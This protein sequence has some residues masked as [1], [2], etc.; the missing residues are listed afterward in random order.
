MT[1]NQKQKH[2]KQFILET[3]AFYFMLLILLLISSCG[4]ARPQRIFDDGG[5]PTSSSKLSAERLNEIRTA[6]TGKAF[7]L[8]ENWY[9]Y[10]YID[11]DPVGGFGE[12]PPKTDIPA[13]IKERSLKLIAPAGTVAEITGMNATRAGYLIFIAQSESGKEFYIQIK[14]RRPATI[15]FGSRN[16]SRLVSRNRF[17]DKMATV[18]WIE[19]MLTYNTVEFIGQPPPPPESAVQPKTPAAEMP[20]AAG[21]PTIVSLI[22]NAAPDKQ[23]IGHP[24]DLIMVFEVTAPTDMEVPVSEKRT[25]FFHDRPLPSYPLNSNKNRRSGKFRTI[26]KQVIP[27]I[28]KPGTYFFKGEV[29]VKNDCISRQVSFDI[30]P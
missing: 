27:K 13:G 14:G 8:R 2:F 20:V 18:P 15:M 9:E 1:L 10:A 22:I 23:K 11:S 16:K 19:R 30:I 17:N 5:V 12:S 4:P 21:P 29:C 26:T 7:V 28:A 24:V 3:P 25:L 6:F